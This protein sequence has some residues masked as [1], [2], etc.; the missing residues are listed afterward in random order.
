MKRRRTVL[1]WKRN[2]KRKTKKKKKKK[3]EEK[4]FCKTQKNI[5]RIN[6][7]IKLTITIPAAPRSQAR[8]AF[9]RSNTG[10][11]GSNL[12]RGMYCL[13]AFFLLL[14]SCVGIGLATG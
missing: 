1:R 8:I 4:K 12:P 10:I 3:E 9:A 13:Y 5:R 6:K 14:F 7:K 11:V 2:I